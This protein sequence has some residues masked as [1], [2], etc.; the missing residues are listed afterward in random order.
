MSSATVAQRCERRAGREEELA[1]LVHSHWKE[2]V[3]DGG[4]SL[5]NWVLLED[6]VCALQDAELAVLDDYQRQP[7]SQQHWED[8]LAGFRDR[9][10]HAE[11]E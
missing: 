2:D 4:R 1:Y 8:A 10:A 9:E 6:I 5:C 7:P 11:A 3:G